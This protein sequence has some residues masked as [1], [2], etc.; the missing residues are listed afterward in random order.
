MKTQTERPTPETDAIQRKQDGLL[1]G[2]ANLE[3]AR[4][5][6]RQRDQLLEAAQLALDEC[7]DLIAT[8]AGNALEAAI[9]NVKGSKS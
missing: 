6:E 3:F 1:C 2:S 9:K 8:K 5:L 4:Y 7:C